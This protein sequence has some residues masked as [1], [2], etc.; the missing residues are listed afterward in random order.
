MG[1]FSLSERVW[2][3]TCGIGIINIDSLL[4]VFHFAMDEWFYQLG[5]P[6]CITI[7]P[8]QTRFSRMWETFAIMPYIL[9]YNT[10]FSRI[11]YQYSPMCSYNL[12]NFTN[13]M[14]VSDIWGII[15]KHLVAYH[16]LENEDDQGL[17][18]QKRLRYSVILAMKNF[19]SLAF[20]KLT[21]ILDAIDKK[22][23]C[24]IWLWYSQ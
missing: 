17:Y 4:N 18:A 9:H 14:S 24:S 10:R 20:C 5:A 8:L 16:P 13:A 21:T 11:K 2:D 23:I 3:A 1:N 19:V 7:Y 6:L 22:Y 15:W 12:D